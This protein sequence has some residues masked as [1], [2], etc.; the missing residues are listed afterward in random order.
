MLVPVLLYRLASGTGPNDPAEIERGVFYSERSAQNVLEAAIIEA[1]KGQLRV[2]PNAL[3]YVYPFPS[4][5]EDVSITAA[6]ARGFEI[7]F[8]RLIPAPSPEPAPEPPPAE[9]PPPVEEPVP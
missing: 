5:V 2:E 3:I 7:D 9:E 1:R 8:S 6:M 4:D